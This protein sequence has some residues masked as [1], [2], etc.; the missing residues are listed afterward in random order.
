MNIVGKHSFEEIKPQ[1][2]D[3]NKIDKTLITEKWIK[4]LSNTHDEHIY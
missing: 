3:N 1:M 4:F 2:D